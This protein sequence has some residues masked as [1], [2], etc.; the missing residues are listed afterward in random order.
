MKVGFWGPRVK[1]RSP[2]DVLQC[3]E[4]VLQQLPGWTAHQA[5]TI[6][7]VRKSFQ[8]ASHA[9][10]CLAALSRRA[11]L[12]EPDRI[13]SLKIL[14]RFR[15]ELE[16]AMLRSIER[17]DPQ[18]VLS[19]ACSKAFFGFS[20]KQGVSVRYPLLSCVPT[21]RCGA[22]CYAHDGRDR[23]L[24]QVFRGVLNY[25][26]GRWYE[27]TPSE[28]AHILSLLR[29]AARHAAFRSVD[30]ANLSLKEE[31][32]S[33][34]P[35]I[36]FSHV[37]EMAATPVFTN[38]LAELIQREV[39]E[40]HCVVYTRHPDASKL[41]TARLVVNFTVEGG[42][43]ARLKFAPRG[44]RIVASAW[45]GDVSAEAEVN[46]LEHHVEKLSVAVGP[47]KV[48]PVTVDHRRFPSCDSAKCTKCFDSISSP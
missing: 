42:A 23:D 24:V 25:Y 41:D 38:D 6:A 44:A 1:G 26:V 14:F 30:D 46:F 31:S 43:D 12:E 15:V 17:L 13:A 48:C 8:T 10:Y 21:K 45:D 29:P 34:P 40:I 35:R 7:E 9:Y 39:S 36:R 32:F 47:A 22:G 33:R 5:Q 19:E 2:A 27:D 18:V 28:R 20:S 16:A 3:A 37:G 4:V 11:V